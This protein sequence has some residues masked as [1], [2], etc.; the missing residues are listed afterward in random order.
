[1][2]SC[3]LKKGQ[4]FKALNNFAVGQSNERSRGCDGDSLKQLF[5]S[6]DYLIYISAQT[7]SVD[8]YPWQQGT[9]WPHMKKIQKTMYFLIS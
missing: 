3:T 7:K 5:E 2:L 9:P 6:T 8:V 4:F 1:M